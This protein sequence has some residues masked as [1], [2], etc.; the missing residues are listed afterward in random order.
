MSLVDCF[1]PLLFFSVIGIF[2]C[3]IISIRSRWGH[4]RDELLAEMPHAPLASEERAMLCAL[5]R[6]PAIRH[7]IAYARGEIP[8]EE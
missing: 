8:A 4:R 1:P 6:R 2:A 3:M 5:C 7:D